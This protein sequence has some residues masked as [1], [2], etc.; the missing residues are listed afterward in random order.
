MV[1]V[2]D[3]DYP[4]RL[5]QEQREEKMMMDDESA[6][7]EEK[8]GDEGDVEIDWDSI[9]KRTELGENRGCLQADVMGLGKGKR[10]WRRRPLVVSNFAVIIVCSFRS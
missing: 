1:G 8:E 7:K 10:L 5:V 9:L 4:L 6:S 2:V 3:G